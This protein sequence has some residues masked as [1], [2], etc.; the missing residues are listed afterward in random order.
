VTLLRSLTGH[1]SLCSLDLSRNTV[2]ET[3]T[4]A[5]VIGAALG[6]L[7]AAD[8]PE[9][10]SL[11]LTN[12]YLGRTGL[13]PLAAALPHNTHLCGLTLEGNDMCLGFLKQDLLM[14]ALLANTSLE[15]LVLGECWRG[16][17]AEERGELYALAERFV[18]KRKSAREAEEA[19]IDAAAAE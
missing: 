5:Q 2:Y 8:A 18:K 17:D 7:I 16:D 6:E 19:L 11:D 10:H 15:W 9:L 13:G 3:G 4:D 14:P 12:C 1:A